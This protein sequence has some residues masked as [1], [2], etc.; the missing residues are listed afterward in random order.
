MAYWIKRRAQKAKSWQGCAHS[1]DQA[2]ALLSESTP[3]TASPTAT[4]LLLKQIQGKENNARRG[5]GTDDHQRKKAVALP[6]ELPGPWLELS[7]W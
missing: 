3:A 6:A 1:T 2:G 4:A 5:A 7:L